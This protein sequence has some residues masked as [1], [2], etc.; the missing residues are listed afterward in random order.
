MEAKSDL[1]EQLANIN[2]R[3]RSLLQRG[4]SHDRDTADLKDTREEKRKRRAMSP[5]MYAGL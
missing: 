3:L 2:E 5:H 1:R 4:A